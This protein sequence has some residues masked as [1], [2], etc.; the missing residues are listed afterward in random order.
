MRRLLRRVGV[1]FRVV[2][3]L[4]KE[5]GEY[6]TFTNLTS[7]KF[8]A[9]EIVSLYRARWKVELLFGELK[10]HFNAAKIPTSN[11]QAAQAML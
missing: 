5:S 9:E 1:T 11:P 7:D 10:A 4:N 6:H 3:I 8:T 2:A